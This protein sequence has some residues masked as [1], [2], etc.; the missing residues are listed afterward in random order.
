M[1]ELYFDNSATT[2]LSPMAKEAAVRVMD[3][4]GNPSSLHSAGLA[5]EKELTA[6]RNNVLAALGSD[7]TK[8]R[9]IF[10]GS[11]SEA[12]NLAILGAARAKKFRG[13]PKIII[14]DSEHPAIE[15]QVRVL[16]EMGWSAV[17]IRTKGGTLDMAQ[18][19]DALDESTAIVSL[20]HVNNET[21]AVYDVATAFKT[22][23]KKAPQAFLHCDA[24]QAFLK[25]PMN[26]HR[27]GCDAVTVSAHKVGGMKGVGA[28][29]F[30]PETEKMRRLSPVIYGGGQESGLRSGTE[31][32]V[33]IAAFG[34]AVKENSAKLGESARKCRALTEQITNE[35]GDCELISFNLPPVRAPHI[36]SITNSRVRSETLV[37]FLSAKG[38]FVSAGSACSSHAKHASSSLIAFGLD[39]NAAGKTVRVSISADYLPEDITRFCAAL[40]EGVLSLAGEK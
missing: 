38:I 22:A 19:E 5:A 30:T 34:A 10:C 18:L 11:G 40:K 4:Y 3:I 37:H 28:L 15:N 2:P 17:R 35:L 31:N 16:E 6:A 25:I 1:K 32:T 7:K 29:W 36:I 26:V 24:V 27:L 23:R 39:E 20:M 33:G 12:N 8:G 14:T 21:G 13:T 9:L